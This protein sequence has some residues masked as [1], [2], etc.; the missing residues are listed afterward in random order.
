MHVY[1]ADDPTKF[2]SHE[3]LW[4]YSLFTYTR[5]SSVKQF[6]FLILSF[7][8]PWP[9]PQD[10]RRLWLPE[11]L[12]SRLMKV[13]RLSELRTGRLYRQEIPLV[14]ISVR[15]KV[16]PGAVVWSEGLSQRKIGNRTFGLV[17]PC[18]NQLRHCTITPTSKSEQYINDLSL[19]NNFGIVLMTKS[20][21]RHYLW[22]IFICFS[23]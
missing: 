9:S 11:F 6:D 18:L 13:V 4:L 16:D 19:E 14:L 2:I 12:D 20:L 7:N 21:I 8:L 17:A 23:N 5:M 10:Y 22:Y 1:C 15:G 3:F